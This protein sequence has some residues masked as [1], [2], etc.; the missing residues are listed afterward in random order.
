MGIKIP[1]AITF[2]PANPLLGIYPYRFEI[3]DIHGSIAFV[4]C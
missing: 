2:D 3:R 1:K 4:K